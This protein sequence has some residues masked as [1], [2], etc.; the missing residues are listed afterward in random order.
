MKPLFV[1]TVQTFGGGI[2]PSHSTSGDFNNIIQRLFGKMKNFLIQDYNFLN[3]FMSLTKQK[4][5]DKQ[6]HKESSKCAHVHLDNI[7]RNEY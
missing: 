4:Y 6:M 7:V 5:K 3:E 1:V 2:F